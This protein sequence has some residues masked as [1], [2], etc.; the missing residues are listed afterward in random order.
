MKL[1]QSIAPA[2]AAILVTACASHTT[3]APDRAEQAEVDKQHAQDDARQARIDAE[4]IPT[5]SAGRS[6]CTTRSGRKGAVRRGGRGASRAGRA[7]GA[8]GRRRTATRGRWARIRSV[9]W[10]GRG[11]RSRKLRSDRGRRRG[12]TTLPPRYA[13]IRPERSSLMGTPTRPAR[14]RRTRAFPSVARMPWRIT[15]KTAASPAIAS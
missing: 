15:S 6:S 9:R 5:R 2:L 7:G 4:K 14:I 10:A 13:P 8:H 3:S 11:V 12:W 1:S